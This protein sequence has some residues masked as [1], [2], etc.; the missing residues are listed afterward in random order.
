MYGY[1]C[2]RCGAPVN[3][4]P[5]EDRICDRCQEKMGQARAEAVKITYVDRKREVCHAG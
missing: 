2:D 3:V 1:K 4:D 5:N